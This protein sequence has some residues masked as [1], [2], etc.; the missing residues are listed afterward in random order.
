MHPVAESLRKPSDSLWSDSE[1]ELDHN[2][3]RDYIDDG[4]EIDVSDLEIDVSE[5]ES[6]S[7]DGFNSDSDTDDSISLSDDEE[8]DTSIGEL[9]P[10]PRRKQ[11]S[12]ITPSYVQERPY[13]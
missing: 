7:A 8:S 6:D 3:Q 4:D 1:D 5:D 12:M 13:L 10:F 2:D 9:K 11:Q